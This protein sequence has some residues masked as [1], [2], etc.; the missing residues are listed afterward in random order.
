MD[1][2]QTHCHI[3]KISDSK[4]RDHTVEAIFRKREVFPAPQLKRD[5]LVQLLIQNLLPSEFDHGIAEI[6]T[7]DPNVL[8]A[9]SSD[10]K[11]DICGSG[12]DIKVTAPFGWI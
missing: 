4:S 9:P 11:G 7:V 12:R 6:E 10:F 5:H 8:E 2:I 3:G 1:F